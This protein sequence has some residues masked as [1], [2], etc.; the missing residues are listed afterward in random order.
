V[1]AANAQNN[2]PTP[3]NAR[4]VGAVLMCLDANG[5]AVP[6]TAAGTCLGS[7]GGGGGGTVTQGP[8]GAAAWLVTGTAGTFPSTQS[9][10]WTVQPG[11]TANT[12]ALLV[13]GTGGSFPITSWGGGTLGAMA[14]YGT[15]PGA[16]L[17][18]GVNA[19]VTNTNANGQATS[20]NSS[21]V[22]LASNQSVADPCTF[23]AKTSK[24]ISLT[25]SGIIAPL[26]GS[27]KI[28][29]CA[30]HLVTAT[31]QNIALVE[32]TG[33]LCV[34]NIYGLAG[35][36]TAATGWNFAANSGI[37][38]GNGSATE[39]SPIADTNSAGAEVCLLLSGSG[40]TSG[41]ISY[42]QQ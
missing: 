4:A 3:G 42:V 19:F 22:T 26:S 8:A 38:L 12:T 6:A 39:I 23:Q 1:T 18:P 41:A 37:S 30:I 16:V 40:Q 14:N 21:P 27:T 7:G 17:V 9:G 13:T 10:T 25:G 24:S 15:S 34:T 2:F 29:I 35:G 36:T 28:Y 31:A 32:G 11:N 33:A 20:A 5:N